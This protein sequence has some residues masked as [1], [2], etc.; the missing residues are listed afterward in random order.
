MVLTKQTY[1]NQDKHKKPKQQNRTN[2]CLV[3]PYEI[4]PEN[5]LGLHS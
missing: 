5:A 1:K 2:P 3:A 4:Q